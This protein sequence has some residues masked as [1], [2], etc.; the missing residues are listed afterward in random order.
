[1]SDG[2]DSIDSSFVFS[3]GAINDSPI[4]SEFSDQ[5]INEDES[6]ESISFTVDEGGGADED[7]QVLKISAA[8]SNPELISGDDIQINFRDDESDADRGALSLRPLKN[9]SGEATITVTVDDGTESVTESFKLK[10]L[11]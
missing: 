7:A 2:I 11:R 9:K 8:S 1:M 10:V 5:E 3:V 4:L 6:I